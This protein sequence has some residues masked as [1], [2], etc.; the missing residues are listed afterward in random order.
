M[1][2]DLVDTWC[3]TGAAELASQFG[4]AIQDEATIRSDLDARL[5]DLARVA[6][7]VYSQWSKQL[8]R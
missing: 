8:S 4:P 1:T 3:Q 2:R 5:A 6:D 7:C